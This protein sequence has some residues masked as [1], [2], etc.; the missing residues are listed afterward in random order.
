MSVTMDF[1]EEERDNEHNIVALDYLVTY[2]MLA[3]MWD[4]FCGNYQAFA[5]HSQV[6]QITSGKV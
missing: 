4:S 5:A 1:S 3:D 6:D 2:Y